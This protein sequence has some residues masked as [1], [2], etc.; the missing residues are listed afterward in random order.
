MQKDPMINTLSNN[1]LIVCNLPT[2]GSLYSVTKILVNINLK[3]GE[4]T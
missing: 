1:M 2:T 4:W 3:F